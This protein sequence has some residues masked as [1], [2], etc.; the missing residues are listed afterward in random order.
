MLVITAS[1]TTFHHYT[2]GRNITVA[3]DHKPLVAIK[4]KPLNKAPRRFQNLLIKAQEY[5][6][7]IEYRIGTKMYVSFLNKAIYSLIPKIFQRKDITL[8]YICVT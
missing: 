2:F 5:N 3:T 8:V 1:L 4:N 6:Y 7:T